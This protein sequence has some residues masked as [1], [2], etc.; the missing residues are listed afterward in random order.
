MEKAVKRKYFCEEVIQFILE[1]N[2]DLEISNFDGDDSDNDEH[3]SDKIVEWINDD[4]VETDDE[5]NMPME[6]PTDEIIQKNKTLNYRWRKRPP[7]EFDITFKGEEF[8]L[9]LWHY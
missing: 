2:S 4:F 1:P 7:P 5:K 9:P 8:S 6:Y 3:V